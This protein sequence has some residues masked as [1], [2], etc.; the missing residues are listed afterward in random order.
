MEKTEQTIVIKRIKKVAAGHHGGSWKIAFADFALAL[1]AFFLVMWLIESTTDLEKM[2]IAGYFSD[3]RS[4][5][6]EGDGGTPYVVDLGGRPLTLANQGLNLALVQDNEEQFVE[7][8]P[9][10]ENQEVAEL[11]RLREIDMLQSMRGQLE[12]IIGGNQSFSWFSE[13]VTIELT[14]NGLAIQITD[15]EN[16][17]IFELGSPQMR[18]YVLEIMWAMAGILGDVPNKISIY[19]HTDSMPFGDNGGTYTNWELS[20]DRANAARRALVEGGL[21]YEQFAQIIGM[22]SSAPFDDQDPTSQANR[23]IVIMVLN[24]RGRRQ[25]MEGSVDAERGGVA[26]PANATPSGEL[27][28]IF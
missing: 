5:A 15:S 25:A 22:G 9:E 8:S 2:V 14:E 1:M 19:G 27:P 24:E 10:L 6:S 20:S 16:R 13:S 26:P 3:P 4:L 17:P 23:R 18:P 11:A 28:V 7:A 21:P 12:E